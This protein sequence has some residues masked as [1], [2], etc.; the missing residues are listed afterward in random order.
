ME[1]S[2][3]AIDT[4][5]LE[6]DNDIE[7]EEESVKLSPIEIENFWKSMYAP[8]QKNDNATVQAV[9]AFNTTMNGMVSADGQQ[10]RKPSYSG[11]KI[12]FFKLSF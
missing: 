2:V 5:G 11:I 6:G 7:A 3:D 10:E 8:P 12:S 4:G 1:L 9:G